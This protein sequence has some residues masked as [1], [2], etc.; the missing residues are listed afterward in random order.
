MRSNKRYF[1]VVFGKRSGYALDYY[2]KEESA[3]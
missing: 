1:A 2:P 3:P